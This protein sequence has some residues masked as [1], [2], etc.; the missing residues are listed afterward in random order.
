MASNVGQELM[1]RVNDRPSPQDQDNNTDLP[2]GSI[3]HNSRTGL[4]VSSQPAGSVVTGACANPTAV[5]A[6]PP[7]APP[8]PPQQPGASSGIR[9]VR[10]AG[11]AGAAAA[12]T[13][14]I[15][16]MPNSLH[17][18][19]IPPNAVTT[20]LRPSVAATVVRPA[21]PTVAS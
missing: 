11:A 3:A 9:F 6:R 4:V 8:A 14:V 2:P 12:A 21:A 1:D 5:L 15:R 7:P 16:A 20:I 13:T 17:T 19:N 18:Q 10:T